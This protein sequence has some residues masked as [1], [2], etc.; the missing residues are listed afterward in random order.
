MRGVGCS[1]VG[2]SF[3]GSSFDALLRDERG[4]VTVEFTVLVPF[5]VFLL[6]LFADATVIYLSHSEMFN[7]ARELSRSVSTGEVRT[8]ADAEAYVADKL[9][10]G[11]RDYYVYVDFNQ[12]KTVTIAV[13]IYDAAIF[14]LWFTPLLGRELVA[15]STV[16]EEPRIE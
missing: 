11:E 4:A 12:D 5:F 9:F 1:F 2:S 15:T 10:L 14:G 6:V 7:A 13:N 3:V 16:A 8:Q